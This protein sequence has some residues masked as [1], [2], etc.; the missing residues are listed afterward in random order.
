MHVALLV[1]CML[2]AVGAEWGVLET[3][4]HAYC[5]AYNAAWTTLPEVTVPPPLRPGSDPPARRLA[6]CTRPCTPAR[7]HGPCAAHGAPRCPHGAGRVR[8]CRQGL[9]RPTRR[10]RR[11]ACREQ[12]LGACCTRSQRLR[13]C[14]PVPG[15]GGGT[16]APRRPPRHVRHCPPESHSRSPR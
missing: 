10:R 7:L 15:G 14:T 5:V 8:L 4:T 12:H 9:T 6:A 13:V 1:A 16:R 11:S 3:P 2:G